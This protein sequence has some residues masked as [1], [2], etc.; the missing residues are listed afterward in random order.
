MRRMSSSHVP[1]SMCRP[2]ISRERN[3]MAA[4]SSY[5]RP[6]QTRTK[7]QP[8]GSVAEC[9]TANHT[10]RERRTNPISLA[11]L[12]GVF[13]PAQRSVSQEHS[14]CDAPG[15][16][17]ATSSG[18]SKGSMIGGRKK[19]WFK[20]VGRTRKARGLDPISL[21]FCVPSRGEHDV[22]RRPIGV[23]YFVWRARIRNSFAA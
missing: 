16:S 6:L 7:R 23:Q 10:V 4:R 2:F 8:N 15:L 22:I 20:G 1:R 5:L 14:P 18:I 9:A 17:R 12:P 13:T 19:C 3:S 21:G 11:H